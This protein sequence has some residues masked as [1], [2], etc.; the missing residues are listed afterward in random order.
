[1]YRSC[2]LFCCFL[3]N[4]SGESVIEFKHVN[5][6]AAVTCKDSTLGEIEKIV[7][8]FSFDKI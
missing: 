7:H 8:T 3:D 6:E 2:T 1:M 4:E 5:S